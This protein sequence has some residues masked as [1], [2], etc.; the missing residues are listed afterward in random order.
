MTFTPAER[1]HRKAENH[2]VSPVSSSIFLK[3]DERQTGPTIQRCPHFFN[4]QMLY[5]T[6]KNPT[7]LAESLL[8]RECEMWEIRRTQASQLPWLQITSCSISWI[9]EQAGDMLAGMSDWLETNDSINTFQHKFS[10]EVGSGNFFWPS[11]SYS[12]GSSD[13]H[14][15]FTLRCCLI[16]VLWKFVPPLHN[17]NCGTDQ[18]NK[19]PINHRSKTRH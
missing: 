12:H 16:S 13:K 11:N 10:G 7:W 9:Q 18:E 1:G 8:S 4:D 17:A 15:S 14:F 19:S 6:L 2:T 5:L 3:G